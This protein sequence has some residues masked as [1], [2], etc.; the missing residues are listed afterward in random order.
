LEVQ[1]M[2]L[3]RRERL[4]HARRPVPV[5]ETEFVLIMFDDKIV[6]VISA[7]QARWGDAWISEAFGR[8]LEL[9]R[10]NELRQLSS[11]ETQEAE[12]LRIWAEQTL[13]HGVEFQTMMLN[14]RQLP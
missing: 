13:K 1:Q 4:H 9:A 11:E 8:S 3:H 6:S 7:L 10:Q 5:G 14:A 12:A 2:R